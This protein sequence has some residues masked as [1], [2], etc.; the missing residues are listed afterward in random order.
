MVYSKRRFEP[1]PW[2]PLL[3]ELKQRLE[4]AVEASFNSA[5]VN[6]YRDGNDSMGWHADN[7]P[8]LGRAPVIASL[9]F[10]ETRSFRLKARALQAKP[11]AI[12]L[13]NGD[14]LVMRGELQRHWQHSIPK[15]RGSGSPRINIT[16]RKIITLA[17]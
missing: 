5:L 8:E 15:T 1:L 9:N 4:L 13:G 11:I 12:N 14:L 17:D 6:L 7:E 10:G 2:H 3:M 16:F